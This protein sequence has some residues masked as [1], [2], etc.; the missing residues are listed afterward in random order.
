[1]KL[2]VIIEW[3][4]KNGFVDTPQT[5]KQPEEHGL[6]FYS[7]KKNDYRIEIKENWNLKYDYSPIVL[8]ILDCKKEVYSDGNNGYLGWMGQNYLIGLNSPKSIN[9]LNELLKHYNI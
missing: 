6:M 4:L 7:Y 1:M 8:S 3:L 5:W 9:L 2:E